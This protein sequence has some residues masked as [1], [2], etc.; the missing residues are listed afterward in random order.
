MPYFQYVVYGARTY[1]NFNFSK[2]NLPP[3]RDKQLVA[4]LPI[5][6]IISMGRV[7]GRGKGWR[8]KH[9]G[10]LEG[11]GRCPQFQTA[12]LQYAREIKEYFR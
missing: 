8:A 12:M 5:Y 7:N 11:G 1:P 6:T 2:D 3:D 10:V 4:P 9:V